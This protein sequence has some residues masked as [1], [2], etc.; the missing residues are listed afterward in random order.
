MQKKKSNVKPK[1]SISKKATPK[2]TK[3][4]SRKNNSGKSISVETNPKLPPIEE[5]ILIVCGEPSGDLL[6]ADLIQELNKTG[7][8]FSYTGIG[9]I[10]MEKLGFNSL[11]D[12]E[13]LSVIGFTGII[14]RYHQLKRIA[15]DLVQKAVEQNIHYAVL[16]D[17]PGFNLHLAEKLREKG[18]KIIF[19]VS[20]QIWAWRFKRIF[21]IQKCV[22]LMLV[23]FPFEK[24]IY[25][26]YN[27]KCEFVGHPLSS[28]MKEK[29]QIE[30]PIQIEKG[31]T[32]ICLM[33]GSRTGEITK[34]LP[35]MLDSAVLIQNKMQSLNRK[36]QFILPNINKSQ[37]A[38]ILET[39]NSAEKNLNVKV[40]YFFDNSAKC[41]EE[42]DLVIL[43][44]GTA[45][46][47]VTYFEKPMIIVYKLGFITYQIGLRLVKAK[48][49]G[50]VNILA[51][52]RICK[53]F[54]QKDVNGNTIFEES[55]QILEDKNYREKMIEEIK[56]VKSS[57]GDGNAGKNASSAILK[58]IRESALL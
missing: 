7:G 38:F 4:V 45:T 31:I 58:L 28:R 52:K 36:V 43:S 13:S 35:P 56:K 47:E 26:E 22:D 34:L 6:G 16:I 8:N 14:T 2:K 46:L 51:G 32:T 41:L 5:K 33:P 20:P 53:E 54:L 39:L 48:D 27:V 50:L 10:E 40:K 21:R 30:K 25:D 12:I 55:M 3:T 1:K 11:H 44:S 19:Y 37:E 9:G 17:Y 49:I 23:L 42:S 29:I 24:A 57:L 15:K 18:I